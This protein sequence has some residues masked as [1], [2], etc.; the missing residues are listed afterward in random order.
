MGSV[1]ELGPEAFATRFCRGKGCENELTAD[2]PRRGRHANLCERCRTQGPPVITGEEK[3]NPP[4]ATPARGKRDWF[5]LTDGDYALLYALAD[6]ATQTEFAAEQ[7]VTSQAITMRVKT[8]RARFGA[9][10][11]AHLIALAYHRRILR[12]PPARA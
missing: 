1:T 3:E 8:L 4:P 2:D 10:N 9:R 7:N 6:G 12:V 11:D 5:G